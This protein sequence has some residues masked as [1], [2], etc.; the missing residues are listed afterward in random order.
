MNRVS[1]DVTVRI[2]SPGGDV[3]DGMAMYNTLKQYG[4]GK[5][6]IIVDG[7]AASAAGM[8]ALAGDEIQAPETASIMLHEAW[9]GIVGNKREM[10]KFADELDK[11]D[12]QLMSIIKAKSTKNAKETLAAFE[13]E[14]WLT[15]S[16]AVEWGFVDTLIEYNDKKELPIFDLSVFNNVPDGLQ[17]IGDRET[18][19]P[20]DLEKALRDAGLSRREAKAVLS[21]GIK[22][23][24]KDDPDELWA[25]A[26][27]LELLMKG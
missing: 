9:G 4:R 18:R 19:Q 21:G 1:G 5:V 12:G 3:F 26:K 22:T 24:E 2:N 27:K 10:R 25:S 20:S 14:L 11:V 6:T 15:G 7:L 17:Q 16:E 13:N 8:I 23:M